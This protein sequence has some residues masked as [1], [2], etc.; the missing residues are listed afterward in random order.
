[1]VSLTLLLAFAVLFATVVLVWRQDRRAAIHQLPRYGVVLIACLA[2]SLVLRQ[3][4]H[5]PVEESSAVAGFVLTSALLAGVL[6]PL[7]RVAIYVLGAALLLVVPIGVPALVVAAAG[8]L[9]A[10]PLKLIAPAGGFRRGWG[11]NLSRT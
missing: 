6:P 11:R 5:H 3:V 8:L 9:V 4:L 2:V 7:L 1:M 10:A